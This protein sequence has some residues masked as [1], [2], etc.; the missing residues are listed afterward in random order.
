MALTPYLPCFILFPL[1]GMLVAALVPA[2]REDIV[3]GVA[4]ATLGLQGVAGVGFAALWLWQGM[5][6]LALAEIELFHKSGYAYWLDLHFDKVTAVFL[7]VGSLLTFLVAVYSRYY[8]H[9]EAGYKRFFL[10]ILLFYTGYAGAIFAGNLETLIVAW[11][12]LGISSF[13]LI[14]FY[15]ER[16]LPVRNAVKIYS[17]YRLG[18]IGLILAMW[19]THHVF[20][21]NLTFAQMPALLA[22]QPELG[23][24]GVALALTLLVAALGK[25]AQLPFSSWLPRAM[26]GPTPSSAIF[27]GALSVHMGVFLLLRTQPLW[28]QEIGIR[29]MMASI[30]LATA[31]VAS[32][33]GRVQSAIKAQIAYASIAQI[34]LMFIEIALG[35][36]DLALL[37]FAGHA[38]LRTYQLLVSP[39][40]V[41]YL[42][43]EQFYDASPA[44]R[45][46]ESY[47]PKWFA[48]SL[49]VWSIQEGHLDEWLRR[50]LW[51]PLKWVGNRLGFVTVQR[52]FTVVLPLLA[53]A[54]FLFAFEDS[55]PHSL[56]QV[57]PSL[58]AGIGLLLVLKAF[59]KRVH[60]RVS[61][62]LV[63]LNHVWIAI[64]VSFN[65]HFQPVEGVFYLSGV[66]VA[67]A[68]GLYVLSRLKRLEPEV[69]LNQF[70]GY[71]QQYPR[72][73]FVFLLACLGVAGFP[74]TTT[75]IGEDLVFSHIHADQPVL[76]VLVA[77]SYI[78]DGLVLIRLYARVFLG[79]NAKSPYEVAYRSA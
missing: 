49:Y 76:A 64:A 67:G 19:L 78:V 47:Y 54:V 13:L 39:S 10:T 53:L 26:E 50:V 52:V 35:W 28:M 18:D 55:L 71:V 12:V 44:S 74:I 38:C 21:A 68:V 62:L 51:Q 48:Y 69:T 65:E 73:A 9:R 1:L 32:G 2:R 8:L 4:F 3:S 57:L 14:A 58:F 20:H 79:P 16:Y 24:G 66:A 41:A 37:H 33:I 60:A 22:A 63:M 59:T 29:W 77:L 75:F 30:G 23:W 72:L 15:R 70:H 36:T 5:P 34:G 46:L 27:Y 25:S 40:A 6:T 7:L 45:S 42:I 56:H 61:F 31:L 43:R 11:E 17:I